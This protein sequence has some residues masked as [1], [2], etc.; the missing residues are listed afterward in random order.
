MRCWSNDGCVSNFH[1]SFLV[2]YL[3]EK[4]N[5]TV[6]AAGVCLT[7]LMISGAAGRVC[8][9]IISDRFYDG[10]RQKPMVILCLIAFASALI[11]TF[12]SPKLPVWLCYFLSA[13][14]GFVFMSW[15][16]LCMTLCAEIA[17]QELAGSVTGFTSMMIYTG[18]IIGPPIFGVITNNAGYFWG[19]LMLSIIGLISACLFTYSI[20]LTSSQLQ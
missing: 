1:Y 7:V 9:G 16:A 18:I 19:W 11:F 6:G 5:F 17:G 4:L 14:I 8:W 20:K 15:N 10:N 12:L 2:L 3:E 13:V